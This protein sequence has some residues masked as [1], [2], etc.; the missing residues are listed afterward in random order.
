VTGSSKGLPEEQLARFTFVSG[1]YTREQELGES[2]G[3]ASD[4]VSSKPC[5]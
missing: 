5:P 1:S 4:T 2:D 3:Q